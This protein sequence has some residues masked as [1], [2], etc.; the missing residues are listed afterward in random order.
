MI[1]GD[2][3]KM[4]PVLGSQT[5]GG[6]SP[7]TAPRLM[8]LDPRSPV[9]SASVSVK[10]EIRPPPV[11]EWIGVSGRENQAQLAAQ[12]VMPSGRQWPCRVVMQ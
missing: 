7:S 8:Q 2:C 9:Q 5:I 10:S 6:L 1:A 11:P 3:S 12:I 4:N